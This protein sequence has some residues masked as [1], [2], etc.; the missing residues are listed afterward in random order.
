MIRRLPGLLL[1]AAIL[2]PAGLSADATRD[3]RKAYLRA[4][5]AVA[6]GRY[7]DALDQYRHVIAILPDDAVVRYEYAQLLRDLNVPDEAIKQAREAVRLDPNLPEARR[8]LG[9]LEMA[10]ADQDPSA[11]DR[12]IEQLTAARRLSPHDT[13]SAVSLA[14]ALLA[15]GRAAEAARL[16]DELPEARTQPALLRLTAEARTKAGRLKEAESLYQTLREADPNDRELMAALIDIYEEQDRIDKALDLLAD[17]Q[18]RDPENPAL[19]ERITLDLAR[20]GRFE[21]AEKKARELAA[22]RPENRDIRRLLASVLFE[23]GEVAGGEQILR[24]LIA[25]DPDDERSRRTLAVELMRERRFSEARPLLE[26]SARRGADDPKRREARQAASVELGYLAFLQRDYVSARTQLAPLAIANGAVNPRAMRILLGVARDSEDFAFGLD[27]VLTAAAA[28]PKSPEWSAAAGEF[29]WRT[30]DHAG[31]TRRLE[32]LGASE[33]SEEALAASDAWSRVKEYAV[34]ARV[35]GEVVRKN[36]ENTEALFRL[37][38]SLERSG[39]TAESEKAFGKLLEARP[40]DPQTL[41]YL[42]YMWAD[43][44][45]HLEKARAMLERAVARDPRNGA[46]QDSLGWVYFRL[47]KI[48]LAERHLK[49]AAEREPDDPTI[50][51]HLGD[52]AEK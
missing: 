16:L 36:P 34:S 3:S 25:T 15:H 21:E 29:L 10:A 50:H 45:V 22:S 49:N 52:L 7:R 31:A 2:L 44:N 24:S 23:K 38:S 35:A 5:A 33:D 18:K 27:R 6:D 42:G 41:N 17:L 11:L 39:D 46:Y 1:C 20:A 40:A 26:E 30:G 9:T 32:K 47:G 19:A 43:K 48:D 51:E 12:A 28:Q 13:S 8:L 14:R 37:A 4:R